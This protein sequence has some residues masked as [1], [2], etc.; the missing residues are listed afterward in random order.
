M[1]LVGEQI[2]LSP[3]QKSSL[4]KP[5][6]LPEGLGELIENIVSCQ[7]KCEKL[8]EE[9]LRAIL[10]TGFVSYKNNCFRNRTYYKKLVDRL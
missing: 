2:Q 9:Q 1:P 5:D 3:E 4:N 6:V 8:A 10:L 7:E